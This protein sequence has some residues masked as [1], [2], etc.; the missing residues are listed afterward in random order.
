MQTQLSHELRSLQ[1]IFLDRDGQA[2]F[3]DLVDELDEATSAI[4]NVV[5]ANSVVN[6][7]FL[8]Q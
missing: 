3:E 4:D 1:P 7:V 6:K 8:L 5:D 2:D